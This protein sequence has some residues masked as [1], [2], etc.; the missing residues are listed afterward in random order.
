MAAILDKLF[1]LFFAP[2][3]R[4]EPLHLHDPAPWMLDRARVVPARR[5]VLRRLRAVFA[6]E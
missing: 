4:I 1:S 2:I 5:G 3:K 6:M